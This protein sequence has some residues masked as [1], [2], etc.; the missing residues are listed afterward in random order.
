MVTVRVAGHLRRMMDGGYAAGTSEAAEAVRGCLALQMV[1]CN[2]IPTV[3]YWHVE[4]WVRG[5]QALGALAVYSGWGA[6]SCSL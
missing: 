5:V 3:T 2:L 1:R 6:S 4:G